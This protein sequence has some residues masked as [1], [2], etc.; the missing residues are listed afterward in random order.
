[1]DQQENELGVCCVAAPISDTLQGLV[2]AIGI[3]GPSLR[4]RD[5]AIQELSRQVLAASRA[6]SRYSSH[7]IS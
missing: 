4:I 5:E 3:S 6:I 7:E 1:V 2:G